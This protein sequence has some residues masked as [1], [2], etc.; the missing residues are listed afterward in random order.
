M[1]TT[2]IFRQAGMLKKSQISKG[3]CIEDRVARETRK[4]PNTRLQDVLLLLATNSWQDVVFFTDTAAPR[5]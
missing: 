1:T 3:C 2:T 5:Q 4:I